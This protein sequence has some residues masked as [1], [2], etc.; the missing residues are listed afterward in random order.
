MLR[1]KCT[2][3]VDGNWL[4]MSRVWVLRDR[5]LKTNDEDQNR[6]AV[7]ELKSLLARSI[8]VTLQRFGTCVDNIVV[9]SDGG[10]WRKKIK[11]PKSLEDV[12]YKGNRTSDDTINWNLIWNT[13][14]DFY[15]N[16]KSLGITY[17]VI[18]GFEGDDLVYYWSRRLN[19]NGINCIIWTTDQ[20]L[21]QLVQYKDCVFTGWYETKKG[22]YIHESAQEK[23]IDPIDFF[24]SGP[25]CDT[26]LLKELKS[27]V[28]INYINPDLIVMKKIICGDDGDNIYSIIRQRMGNK[29]YKVGE[30]QWDSIRKELNLTTVKEFFRKRDEICESLCEMKKF[31]NI[32]QVKEE[33]D[34]N[35]KLVWLNS[36]V[37][38]EDL[39]KKGDQFDYSIYDV[40]VIK[41]NFKVLSGDPDSDVVK[42]VFAGALPF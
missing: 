31:Q 35:R 33:F 11:K 29:I 24:M 9:V 13:A 26:R 6:G 37:I 15:E 38:P 39:I 14:H 10:T 18:P 2:L 3:I 19:N 40:N 28:Q 22:L 34:Y 1:N 21:M 12:I 42:E 16:C 4:L 7:E 27:R 20:D 25:V 36:E 5:F 17:S 32:E 23:P 8:S 30:K 41:N